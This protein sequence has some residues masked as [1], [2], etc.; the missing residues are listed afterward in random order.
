MPGWFGE[1]AIGAGHRGTSSKHALLKFLESRHEQALPTVQ[2]MMEGM[3]EGVPRQCVEIV[4]ACLLTASE[5]PSPADIAAVFR[6]AY[7]NYTTDTTR[8][9]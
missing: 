9:A 1:S 6:E 8:T 7:D 2:E 4:R 3:V 5:R